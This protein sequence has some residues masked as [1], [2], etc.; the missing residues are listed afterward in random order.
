MSL[1]FPTE[2]Q[3]ERPRLFVA[4]LNFSVSDLYCLTVV[5]ILDKGGRKDSWSPSHCS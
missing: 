4:L 5:G 3:I 1:E 2:F